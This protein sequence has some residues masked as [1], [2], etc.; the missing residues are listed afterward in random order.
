MQ[1]MAEQRTPG[2]QPRRQQPGVRNLGVHNRI[3]MQR[4]HT[5]AHGS[6]PLFAGTVKAGN[7][8]LTPNPFPGCNRRAL[9]GITLIEL[10]CVMV[11]ITILASMLLPTAA[12]AYNRARALAEEVEGEEIIHLLLTKT[13]GYCAGHPKYRFDSKA[14]FVE[15]CGLA[16]KPRAW[17]Q[18]SSTEFLPFSHLDPTNQIVLVFHVGRNRATRYEFDVGELST[19][20]PER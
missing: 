14:D 19:R 8:D 18:A 6:W 7:D 16:P 11:I 9:K 5:K 20:P 10:L 15:K 1:I 3:G 17:I 2:S 12:R 13:R 4:E